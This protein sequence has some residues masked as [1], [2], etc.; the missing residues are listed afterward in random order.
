MSDQPYTN[1]DLIAEAARQHA[2]LTEDPDFMG[3]GEAME[4]AGIESQG[5][6]EDEEGFVD[7]AAQAWQWDELLDEDEFSAAQRKIH[8]LIN[9]AADVSAWA[10]QLGADGLQPEDHTLSV[11]ADDR[12]LVRLHM[13][14]APEL[15][16]AAR[17]SFTAGL[18]RVI[19]DGL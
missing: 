11:D 5:P 6:E 15:D 2:T 16:D 3:V 4:G 8:D 1:D 18:A 9:G 7:P 17:V 19:A 10:V 13:A 14:F 12:P